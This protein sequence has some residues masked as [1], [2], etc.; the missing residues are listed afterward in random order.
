MNQ[1]EQVSHPLQNKKPVE[2]LSAILKRMD[3][4]VEVK[5][6][7]GKEQ[8]LLDIVG[9]D[10][11]LLTENKG[12]LLDAMQ[13]VLN[14]ILNWPEEAKPI[15]IDSSGYLLRRAEALVQLAHRLKEEV[16]RTG[17]VIALNPMSPRDR[18]IIHMALKDHPGISTRSE[19]EGAYRRLF[20]VPIS[21]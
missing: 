20:I 14:R 21:D 15:F 5:C 9:A 7:E 1:E 16:L 8:I 18:K 19:G 2:I 17:K 11:Y 6:T 4:E 3:F 12:E 13:Y 10:A